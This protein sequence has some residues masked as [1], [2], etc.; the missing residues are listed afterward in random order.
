MVR[1]WDPTTGAS[2][3]TLRRR[4]PVQSVTFA[5]AAVAIGD[6]EGISVV[7]LNSLAGETLG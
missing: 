3:A 6:D 5:G 4:F 2:I 7:E 1:L